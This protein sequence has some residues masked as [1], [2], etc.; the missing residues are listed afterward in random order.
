MLTAAQVAENYFLESR[1]MLLEV[2]AHLDRFDAAAARDAAVGHDGRAVS[3]AGRGKMARLR[4]AIAILAADA[5]G[6]ER[7]TRLL[8]LFA[9]E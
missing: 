6:H 5:D 4:E 1:H 9:K 7:T 3:S 8:E 2:A